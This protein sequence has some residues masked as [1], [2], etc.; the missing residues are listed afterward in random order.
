[1]NSIW[2]SR[3]YMILFI[4]IAMI[5]ESFELVWG[6]YAWLCPAWVFILVVFWT[7]HYPQVFSVGS[8]WLTGLFMDVWTAELLGKHALL[9]L[10]TSFIIS[11]S[12]NNLTKY[13]ATDR[14][15]I[16]AA[17]IFL[18]QLAISLI[19]WNMDVLFSIETTKIFGT[20]ISSILLWYC[21]SWLADRRTGSRR[22]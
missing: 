21:L 5:L 20:I 18:Y 17:I 11:F 10:I 4:M 14:L 19:G 16:I 22:L 9:F 7:V 1:M 3:L 8:A 13:S 2:L 6:N 15:W 12:Y